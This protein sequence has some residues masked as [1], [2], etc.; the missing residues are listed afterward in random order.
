MAHPQSRARFARI[1]EYVELARAVDA[2]APDRLEL[3]E[4]HRITVQA[5][6]TTMGGYSW[7]VSVAAGDR[8]GAVSK[9]GA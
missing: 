3:L 6:L 1:R 4:R 8:L 2:T 7:V 9:G 5:R